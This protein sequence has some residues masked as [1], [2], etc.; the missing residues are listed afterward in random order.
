MIIK[1]K[2]V[3]PISI[4]DFS[5]QKGCNLV[6]LKLWHSPANNQNT[7]AKVKMYA[8]K[9]KQKNIS[10]MLDIHYSDTWADPTNQTPPL[11]WQNLTQVQIE[12]RVYNYTKDVILQLKN[13][14]T[15]PDFVQIG[16]ETDSG[17]LWN[18]GKVWNQYS[19]N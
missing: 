6:R 7:L 12:N 13:Q 2:I 3:K 4:L 18:Y 5:Q 19:N 14:G 1:T 9:L 16:N 11:A 17:F 8:L 10:F 15:S